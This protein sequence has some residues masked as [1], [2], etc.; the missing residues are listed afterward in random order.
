[1]TRCEGVASAGGETTPGRGKR[2]NDVSWVDANF[3]GPKD[4]EN[5]C[6]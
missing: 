5:S 1:V 2:G 4:K 6:N 3:T